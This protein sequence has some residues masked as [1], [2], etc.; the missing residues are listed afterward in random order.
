VATCMRGEGSVSVSSSMISTAEMPRSGILLGEIGGRKILSFQNGSKSSELYHEGSDSSHE[1]G[2]SSVSFVSFQ[3][4]FG[5][6]DEKEVAS[7]QCSWSGGNETA[8]GS[9]NSRS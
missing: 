7:T 2:G 5:N 4:K 9:D 1:G 3:G 6:E 8:A